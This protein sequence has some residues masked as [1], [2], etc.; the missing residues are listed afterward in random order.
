[1]SNSPENVQSEVSAPATA[2]AHEP[3]ACVNCR[4]RK[5]KCD[6]QKPVCT[7]CVKAGGEC[8]YPESRRKPAK[9]RNV[10]ELE[11]RLAQV[12]GLL[13]TVSGQRD[14]FAP[15]PSVPRA[16]IPSFGAH[17]GGRPTRPEGVQRSPAEGSIPW[18]PSS[19]DIHSPSTSNNSPTGELLGLGQFETLPPFE[20]IDDLHRIYLA[21]HHKAIP[22]IHP[23]NYLRAFHSPPHMRPPM[24]LQYAIW[25][26]ASNGHPKYGQYHD[27][28][29]RRAR[30]YLEADELKGCGEHFI[31]IG[32]AQAWA[33]IATDEVRSLLFTRAAMSTARCVRLVGMMG[34]H[35]LDRTLA[36]EDMP[37]TPM[38]TPPKSW[39]ELEERR[40]LFWGAF[41]I[42]SHTS[43]STGWPTM[44]DPDQ[45]TTHMP[46][47]DQAFVSGI[48]E[49][50]ST[51]QDVFRGSSYSA[52]GGTV[53]IC[54]LLAQLLK[55]NHRPMPDDR[56]EDVEFGPFWK[57]HRELDNM[58]SSVFMF[59][60]EAFRLPEN[61]RDPIA[62]QTN[63]SLHAAVICLHNAACDKAEQYKLPGI[64]QK[65]RA[66]ALTAAQEVVDIIKL[67]SHKKAENMSPL[68]V[69]ALYCAASVYVAQAKDNPEEFDKANLELL[70]KFMHSIKRQHVIAGPYLNQVIFDI[71]RNG[72]SDSLGI[73]LDPLEKRRCT[74]HGIPLV[75]R[76]SV[77]R[78][79]TPQPPLPGRLPLGAPQD[80]TYLVPGDISPTPYRRSDG[81]DT[82][83]AKRKRTDAGI[84][85]THYPS[86]WSSGQEGSST[87]LDDGSFASMLGPTEMAG[88][89]YSTRL[90]NITTLP[91]RTASP[92][93]NNSTVSDTSTIPIPSFD[94]FPSV[95]PRGPAM[96]RMEAAFPQLSVPGPSGT[97]GTSFAG[98]SSNDTTDTNR[99][100]TTNNTNDS[101]TPNVL[102]IFQAMDAWDGTDPNEFCQIFFGGVLANNIT[103]DFAS[104]CQDGMNAWVPMDS[105]NADN[106]PADGSW[107]A[108][109]GGGASGPG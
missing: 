68:L 38:I 100:T 6:R 77:S 48:E 1:M 108:H 72:L 64:R 69:L 66:R 84:T 26:L 96:Q 67:T 16:S 91:H 65:S 11:E 79:S 31:T 81:A 10:R 88:W 19:S 83:A 43:I 29:Y 80:I 57:R 24:S 71:K 52:F 5:L 102:D 97:A 27:A 74:P 101:D 7:R 51:L 44:I 99:N 56:P 34:L 8:V 90:M 103:G 107:N 22:I 4:N 92:A 106:S 18:S 78:H 85:T 3:L 89:S 105:D 73:P 17:H 47:S 62:V 33:L 25:T 30:Q 109:G 9:R 95:A 15:G 98:D 23:G 50:G 61:V 46:S 37:I 13:R 49:A 14:S 76:G 54:F 20:M 58:L 53:V 40:R 39:I 63:L 104:M 86:M 70:I 42:D 32:H 87:N 12:E 2:P 45:I 36:N 93:L 59:L 60:P 28:L 75:A 41:C 21:T 94:T 35:R 55:H 82:P